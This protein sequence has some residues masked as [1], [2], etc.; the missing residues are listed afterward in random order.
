MKIFILTALS[1]VVCTSSCAGAKA[2]K[3]AEYA[4]PFQKKP[5]YE[6]VQFPTASDRA[7]S[8][9]RA[10]IAENARWIA[11]NPDVVVVLSGHCDERGS[12]EFNM[13][14]GDRRARSVKASLIGNGVNESQL[15]SIVSYGE[16]MPLD[17]RHNREAW[18]KNRRVELTVR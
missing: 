5:P 13:E 9:D 18:R 4:A 16:R 8:N 6:R 17:P 11:G 14:L 2:A 15:T 7:V 12:D 3:V 10:K 1:L